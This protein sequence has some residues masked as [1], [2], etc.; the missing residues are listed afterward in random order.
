MIRFVR[1]Q[2]VDCTGGGAHGAF[3][4]AICYKFCFLCLCIFMECE[5]G[6]L[7]VVAT[8]GD[9]ALKDANESSYETVA[10]FV[11]VSGEKA[12]LTVVVFFLRT[13]GDDD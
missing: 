11:W 9:E 4:C 12:C 10:C 2:I 1:I 13:P 6:P 5:W 8:K 3:D 7:V